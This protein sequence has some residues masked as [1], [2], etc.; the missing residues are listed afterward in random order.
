M[1]GPRARKWLKRLRR[2]PTLW[3]RL[4]ASRRLLPNAFIV[5]AQRSGT[6]SCYEYLVQHPKIVG[7][8][9]KEVH[10][11]DR[12]RNYRRGLNWYRANF[13]LAQSFERL[14]AAERPTIVLDATPEYMFRERATELLALHLPDARLIALL[15][16]PVARAFSQ[17]KLAIT[18]QSLRG[19]FEEEVLPLLGQS[20]DNPTKYKSVALQIIQRG[21][22]A[23][24]IERLY[25]FFP[26]EQLHLEM[27]EDL[28]AD[29]N[30][31]CN[32]ILRHLGLEPFD[33]PD[34]RPRNSSANRA[35]LSPAAEAELRAYYAPHNARLA[36]LLGRDLPW[37]SST[38][39]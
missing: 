22:Y 28:Y 10:F 38:T 27:A 11:F 14:P 6:T 32:R 31:C 34:P 30:S 18:R 15:R 19:S 1:I 17:Y 21:H 29:P 9:W 5:G 26:R 33:L 35:S 8:R 37:A 12:A 24:Q 23:E 36:E 25:A 3:R 13:D 16:D 4:S 2:E 39:D 7:P 20:P